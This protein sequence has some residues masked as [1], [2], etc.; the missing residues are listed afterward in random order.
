MLHRNC[1]AHHNLC[2]SYS[3][4]HAKKHTSLLAYSLLEYSL[5][6][7]TL[8]LD[9]AKDMCCNADPAVAPGEHDQWLVFEVTDTGCG[10]SQHGLGS[11]FTEYVQVLA[12]SWPDL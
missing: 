11:L 4:T 12:Q 1:C 9:P 10:I 5:V 7:Y 2:D 3:S 8:Q 6:E